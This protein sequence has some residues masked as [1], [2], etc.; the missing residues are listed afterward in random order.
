[1]T[2]RLWTKIALVYLAFQS[3]QLGLWALLAPKSFYDGFPGFGRAWIS[4][5]G[6]YNEHMVR[7]F[8]A[9]NLALFVVLVGAIITMSRQMITTAAI[10]SLVW[11][12]PHVIY[13][14][15]N[16][17]GYEAGADTA[18]SVGGLIF[19]A[20]VAGSL[21]FTADRLEHNELG[22]RAD[23]VAVAK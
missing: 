4:I 21:L 6:P 16:T 9:L 12:V 10:A 8:G 2:A 1:M 23:D 22:G 20:V 11:G 15:V 3:V 17:D 5:D 14:L 13:H 18:L 19:F 7:D